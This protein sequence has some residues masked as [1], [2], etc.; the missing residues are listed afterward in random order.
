MARKLL[1]TSIFIMI[2][3]TSGCSYV[4]DAVKGITG[5]FGDNSGVSVDADLSYQDGN[6]SYKG[7]GNDM[8]GNRFSESSVAGSDQ[9]NAKNI[10]VN[11]NNFYEIII[12]I[13]VGWFI[14][15]F[16]FWWMDSHPKILFR[17]L[18]SKFKYKKVKNSESNK[19]D[20]DN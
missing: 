20:N 13:V 18:K 9:Y 15:C 6:N 7:L 17:Y 10:F 8:T 12:A 19:D 2:L 4:F 5:L 16:F 1:I 3:A 11:N 14:S